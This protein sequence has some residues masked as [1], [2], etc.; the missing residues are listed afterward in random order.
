MLSW[1]GELS[2]LLKVLYCIAVPSTVILIIQTILVIVGWDDGAGDFDM[3]DDIADGV[4][5]DV[6]LADASD[7]AQMRLFTLQTVIAFLTVFGWS[8]IVSLHAGGM[9][10]SSLVIG[11]VFGCLGMFLVAKFI[12]LSA[13]L[14]E[15]GTQNLH[16]A[17]GQ[18]ATVYIPIPESEKGHGKVTFTLQGKFTECEAV[19]EGDEPLSAGTK[20]RIIDIVD[21]KLVVEKE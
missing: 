16:Y 3:P 2:I 6:D 4:T 20:V 17:L 10:W 7:F 14:Q 12:Q 13:K 1:W 19:T 18:S 21:D 8:S 15:N 11:F 9:V 5:D